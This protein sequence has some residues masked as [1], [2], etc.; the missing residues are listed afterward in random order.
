[1]CRNFN[2]RILRNISSSSEA[3]DFALLKDGK[4]IE[5][6]K[7]EEQSNFQVGDIFIAKIRKPVAG[8]NAAFVNV[9]YEK[10]AFLH[11]HDLGPN[12]T[13]YLKFI[14]LV[15]TG[16]LKDFSLKNFQFE[17]EINK[18][19]TVADILSANQSLL[20]QVVKEPDRKSVV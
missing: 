13:S 2:C 6:H 5:L 16:K 10:D 19:G 9:G 8:L 7:E 3:V 17:K 4:L 20:V 15:S 11:Y 14:K 18:D 12:L 1:M